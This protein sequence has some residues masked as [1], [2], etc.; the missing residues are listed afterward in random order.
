[1]NA[2]IEAKLSRLL[3]AASGFKPRCAQQ[4]P[5]AVSTVLKDLVVTHSSVSL[6][7]AF[8]VLKRSH[9]QMCYDQVQRIGE[10]AY[11]IIVLLWYGVR[12]L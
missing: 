1:M 11:L 6:S 5:Q 7:A 8:N 12:D 4:N 3:A 2:C 9:V 10:C